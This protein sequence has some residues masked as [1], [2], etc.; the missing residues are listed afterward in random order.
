MFIKIFVPL[1]M[2]NV[3]FQGQEIRAAAISDITSNVQS[4]LVLLEA[5]LNPQSRKS[6]KIVSDVPVGKINDLLYNFIVF[7]R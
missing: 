3:A 6:R 4:D 2:A 7:G 5:G 1:L